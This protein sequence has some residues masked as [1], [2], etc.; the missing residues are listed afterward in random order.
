MTLGPTGRTRISVEIAGLSC[1]DVCRRVLSVCVFLWDLTV[2]LGEA[3]SAAR[4]RQTCWS[5]C[6][7]QKTIFTLHQRE[8]ERERV[9]DL[10][11]L[12]F[13][14]LE[15]KKP[16]RLELVG[17]TR[18]WTSDVETLGSGGGVGWEGSRPADHRPLSCQEDET[19]YSC[20]NISPAPSAVRKLRALNLK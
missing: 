7:L 10:N 13:L 14:C 18:L 6:G 11:L 16:T 3:T 5:I 12:S 1:C 8:T 19:I 17:A 15:R 4:C 2:T 20:Y 9:G